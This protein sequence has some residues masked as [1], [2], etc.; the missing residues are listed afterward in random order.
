MIQTTTAPGMTH[1]K[2]RHKPKHKGI[3]AIQP[4]HVATR[5]VLRPFVSVAKSPQVDPK[6]LISLELKVFSVA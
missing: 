1:P 2:R 5:G 3:A 4:P 6:Y